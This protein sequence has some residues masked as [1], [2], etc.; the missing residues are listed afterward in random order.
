MTLPRLAG[1]GAFAAAAGILALF[2]LFVW[3]TRP[4]ATGGMNW[5]TSWVTWIAVG[6]V[7]AALV[8]VHV[9]YGRILLDPTRWRREP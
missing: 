5:S 2:A 6:G 8:A 1:L 3:L 7:V 9:V 4:D